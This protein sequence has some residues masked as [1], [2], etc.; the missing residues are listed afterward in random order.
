MSLA[1]AWRQL[2]LSSDCRQG[3]EDCSRWTGQQRQK[4]DGRMRWA[5][6]VARAVDFTQNDKVHCTGTKQEKV[7][8]AMQQK[9]P[10]LTPVTSLA[11][12]KVGRGA[13]EKARLRKN[14]PWRCRR[15]AA[16]Q[17]VPEP[18][19]GGDW[20]RSV[21][22]SRQPFTADDQWRL[23]DHQVISW[24]SA[25]LTFFS[26][27]SLV[28]SI[29]SGLNFQDICALRHPPSR[30]K[31]LTQRSERSFQMTTEQVQTSLWWWRCGPVAGKL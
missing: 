18:Q 17:F 19:G 2:R 6:D 31:G 25:H 8:W 11:L 3:A 10:T 26:T 15:D 20:E 30:P 4:P 1:G 9:C 24:H 7:Q 27:H 22:D 21:A 14:S 23:G 5:G 28:S 29:A 13:A 12:Q 16:W